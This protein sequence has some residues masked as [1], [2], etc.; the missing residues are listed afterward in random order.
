MEGEDKPH[1]NAAWTA[2]HA[3]A[4][5]QAEQRMACIAFQTT[6]H[7]QYSTRLLVWGQRA[8]KPPR[9]G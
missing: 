4:S 8:A 1:G 3:S 5:S 6:P 7:T 9:L 2:H